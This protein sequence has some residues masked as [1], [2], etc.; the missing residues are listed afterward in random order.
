MKIYR[1]WVNQLPYMGED[2]EET[3]SGGEAWSVSSFQTHRQEMNILKFGSVGGMPKMVVGNRS[4]KSELDRIIG[5]AQDGL[6]EIMDIR[7]TSEESISEARD[8]TP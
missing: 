7:I 6:L 1:I 3:Y 2:P 4:L 8:E 5:R